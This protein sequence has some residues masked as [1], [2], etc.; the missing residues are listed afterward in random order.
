MNNQRGGLAVQNGG[1]ITQAARK[2]IPS[3][4]YDEVP[5]RYT[6]DRLS[7]ADFE[8]LLKTLR[9]G[10]VQIGQPSLL[11]NTN[12]NSS[13]KEAPKSRSPTSKIAQY[14]KSNPLS[15][16]NTKDS[17][18]PPKSIQSGMETTSNGKP[19]AERFMKESQYNRIPASSRNGLR[20]E[21]ISQYGETKKFT[22]KV[23]LVKWFVCFTFVR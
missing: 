1:R 22:R 20:S 10:N 17:V 4:L 16:T 2:S 23:C 11:G 5:K 6:S 9:S 18:S 19:L 7:D 3:Q 12:Y 15:N 21:K 13:N 8:K 14:C